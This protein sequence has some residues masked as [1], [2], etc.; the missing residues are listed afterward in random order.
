MVD[1]MVLSIE[2][3]ITIV[4][5]VFDD[6]LSAHEHFRLGF[7]TALEFSACAQYKGCGQGCPR[8]DTHG[9]SYENTNES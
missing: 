9:E 1:E 2:A 3:F 8:S 6:L 7:D 4:E 5:D